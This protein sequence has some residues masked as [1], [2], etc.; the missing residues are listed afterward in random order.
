VANLALEAADAA[1][2]RPQPF[3]PTND[4]RPTPGDNNGDNNGDQ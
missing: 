1:R 4:D 2:R 3:S